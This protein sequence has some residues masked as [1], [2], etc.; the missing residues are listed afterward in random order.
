MRIAVI[1]SALSPAN[2]SVYGSEFM[3]AILANELGKE[4]DVTLYA[5]PGSMKG[6]YKLRLLPPSYSLADI[7]REYMGWRWYEDEILQADYVIDM[8]ATCIFSERIYFLH[9]RDFGGFCLWFRN[10]FD[11]SFP[12][13]P[14]SYKLHGA[15][16][17]YAAKKYAH[18]RWGIPNDKLHVAYYGL[19]EDL[20]PYSSEKSEYILY[21]SRPHPHKG[22]FK[23]CIIAKRLPDV[24][25]IAAYDPAFPDHRK[26]HKVFM[27]VKPD[28]VHY[29]PLEYSLLKKIELYQHARA[30]LIPHADGYKEAFGLVFIEALSSGTP[31]ITSRQESTEEILDDSVAI[32][33][34]NIDDYVRAVRRI[35]ID[36]RECREFFLS[37][38]TSGIMARRYLSILEHAKGS[39]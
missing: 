33:C 2:A 38:Y 16:L 14:V 1:S 37:R 8:S 13:P 3:S 17:S 12:R 30:L 15:C 6:N 29:I 26:Y 32:L 19:P 10:G 21:L 4:H 5:A 23:L 27:R 20:Y 18:T 22:L 31:I 39:G 35:D 9:K 28:N 24:E 7:S 11:F 25:F 36:P 34:K